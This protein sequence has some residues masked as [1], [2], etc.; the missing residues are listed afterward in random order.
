MNLGR[1]LVDPALGVGDDGV[2]LPAVP[3]LVAD[4]DELL[5]AFVSFLVRHHI[6]QPHRLELVLTIGR[7]HVPAEAPVGQVIQR[8]QPAD[9]R[10]GRVERGRDGDPDPKLL[11]RD[12]DDR[13]K[14]YRI[15]NGTLHG[16]SH[17]I[18]IA[19]LVDV[20]GSQN[21]SYEQGIELASLEDA[22]HLLPEWRPRV[23]E[24]DL[25]TRMR[26]HELRVVDHSVLDEA[27]QMHLLFDAAENRHGVSLFSMRC[28]DG[29]GARPLPSDPML[30][31]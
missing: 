1:I 29:K 11:G 6:G 19:S 24:A 4:V 3:E 5:G 23:V 8:R 31:G 9:H 2:V 14:R 28:G 13:N 25:V 7:D 12:A 21:I 27:Q 18:V 10:I 15:V 22:P 16:V 30:R 26:P 17:R 20:I